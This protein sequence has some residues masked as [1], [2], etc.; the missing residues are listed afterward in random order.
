MLNTWHIAAFDGLEFVQSAG[1]TQAL[2]RHFHEAYSIG[3]TTHGVQ[4]L[5]TE[6][7]TL[8]AGPSSLLLASPYQVLAHAPLPG[9]EWA[10]KMLHVSPDAIPYLQRQDYIA[11]RHAL[12]FAA[13]VADFPA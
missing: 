13:P 2:P 4:R 6:E 3:L 9:S 5:H 10:H 1:I 7:E 11:R 8:L 12:T